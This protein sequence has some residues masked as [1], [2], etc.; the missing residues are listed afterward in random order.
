MITRRRFFSGAAALAGFSALAPRLVGQSNTTPPP[1]SPS[2]TKVNYH[3]VVTP[4]GSTLPWVLK[5]GL[6][7][8]HLIAEPVR[9]EFAPGM[10]VNCWGYNGQSPG[11][12]IEAVE[13]DRV[14]ILVTN[15]LAEP[16]TVHWHGIITPNGM[17][18]VGGV[19]QKHIPP[20]ETYA[21]EFTLHQNGAQ[22]YHPHSDEM[23][24][25]AMG[26]EGFFIIH[27]R[28]GY[29]EP[30]GRHFLIFLQEWA[31]QPGTY[32]PDPNVMTDFNIFTFNSRVWPGT[33]PLVVRLGDRVRVSFANLSMDSHPIHFHGHRW[34]LV[35]TDGGEVPRSASIPETTI[36]V[37]PGATR[38]V[39]FVADNPGDWPLHCHKN[40]HAMNAMSHAIPN[41]LGADQKDVSRK[42]GKLVPGY[43]AMGETGMYEMHAMSPMMRG[44]RNTLPMMA[45]TGPFGPIGMGGMFTLLKVREGITTY[46]DPGWY[47][48]PPGT[49][50]SPVGGAS[51]PVEQKHDHK[52]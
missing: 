49:V 26:M 27:P 7:E 23:I 43:M 47:Q 39:E 9:R 35:G 44:P 50:A 32:T 48:H 14:R 33:D 40:H 4:N 24:Q 29:S 21:Y 6:K 46:E 38:T 5:D 18:G 1:A 42:I 11:P 15:K 2:G 52:T 45:G 19:T 13:G 37:P 28:A 16:T 31:I 41:V 51:A 3:P 10:E 12:T 30:V 34:W 8:F 36:H 25:M 17:D 20:G 22:M